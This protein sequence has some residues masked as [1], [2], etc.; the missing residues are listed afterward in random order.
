MLEPNM[1]FFRERVFI[2]P[3]Q[4]HVQNLSVF[5]VPQTT[6]PVQHTVLCLAALLYYKVGAVLQCTVNAYL[7][8]PNL[9]TQHMEDRR[10][11]IS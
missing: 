6:A 10:H 8:L 9:A 11:C 1:V 5:S 3:W 7:G 2:N 4:E